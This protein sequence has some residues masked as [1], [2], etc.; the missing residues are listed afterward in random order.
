MQS[1][2]FHYTTLLINLVIKFVHCSSKQE[3]FEQTLVRWASRQLLD[4]EALPEMVDP[5]LRGLFSPKQ[6]PL[7]ADIIA[8]CLQVCNV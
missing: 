1:I 6:L 8:L 2:F 3:A 5:A 7:F 4:I